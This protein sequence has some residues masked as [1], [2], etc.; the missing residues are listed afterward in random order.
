MM[1]RLSAGGG[2]VPARDEEEGRVSVREEDNQT[3]PREEQRG[4][5]AGVE[6]GGRSPQEEEEEGCRWMELIEEGVGES[7][8]PP[9]GV[10]D[11]DPC[12]D[13]KNDIYA[14]LVESEN[15]EAISNPDFRDQLDA[16][17]S[18]LP[19]SYGVD[20]NVDRADAVLLHQKLLEDAKDPLKRPAF[21]VRFMKV[22]FL[23][24]SLDF[25][26]NLYVGIYALISL[27]V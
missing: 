27:K 23:F 22:L 26:G 3:S 13:I 15:P 14:R 25:H 18:R 1:V 6:V 17:F 4:V 20:I 21:H 24:I 2:G 19:T 9:R 16:H 10:S 12:Y 8:S 11:Q 7:S 5:T